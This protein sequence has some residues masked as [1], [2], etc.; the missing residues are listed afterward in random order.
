[1][2]GALRAGAAGPA[3][4][5][6]GGPPLPPELA[7]QL[8]TA[9]KVRARLAQTSVGAEPWLRALERAQMTC[10]GCCCLLRAIR[11]VGQLVS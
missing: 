9:D 10:Y 4:S 8:S 7:A 5:V 1:M 11:Q 6:M 2:R 3:A